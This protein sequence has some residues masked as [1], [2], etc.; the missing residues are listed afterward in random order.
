M[1]SKLNAQNWDSQ[2][3]YSPFYK[4]FTNYEVLPSP[5]NISIKGIQK[6]ILDTIQYPK[7]F[8][9]EGLVVI[10]FIVN[11][12]GKVEMPKILKGIDPRIEKQILDLIAD[13]EFTPGKFYQQEIP[14]Y[15]NLPLRIISK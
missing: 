15:V 6:F 12:D 8:Q 5:K 11:L 14:M 7:D 2:I 9:K 13:F 3:K 1:I 4:N 10:R